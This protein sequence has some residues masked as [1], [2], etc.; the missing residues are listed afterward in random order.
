[1][2]T[3]QFLEDD[4]IIQPDDW[5]RPLM[6]MTMSGGHSDHMSYKSMYSGTPENNVRWVQ[7][8]DVLGPVWKGK[9]VHDYHAVAHIQ[10]EFVRGNV[11]ISHRQD[12][13]DYRSYAKLWED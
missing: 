7:V 2:I 13:K 5:C 8:C 12:M 9:R 4:D 3:V 6:L 11:P 1:M 10:L